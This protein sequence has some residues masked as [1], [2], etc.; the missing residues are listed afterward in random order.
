[1]MK[2]KIIAVLTAF[3][4]IGASVVI[5]ITCFKGSRVAL[6]ATTSKTT[7]RSPSQII[8]NKSPSSVIESTVD[9][10]PPLEPKS[11]TPMES[12]LSKIKDDE[13]IREQLYRLYG[14]FNGLVGN[15]DNYKTTSKEEW[16][17]LLDYNFLKPEVFEKFAEVTAS[18]ELKKDFT[19]VAALVAHARKGLVDGIPSD[20]DIKALRYAY[21]IVNDVQIWVLPQKGDNQKVRHKF[22]ASFALKDHKQAIIIEEWIA[23]K[24]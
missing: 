18:P 13:S 21:E 5:G 3:L 20:D 4:L 6:K 23:E 19:S 9:Q 15:Y 10:Y 24:S 17:N 14:R 22:G 16:F 2:F 7:L 1:M 11:L 8:E 12:Y